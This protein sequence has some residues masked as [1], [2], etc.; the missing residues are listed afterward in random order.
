MQNIPIGISNYETIRTND[1]YYVDKTE[2][3]HELLNGNQNAV[4]L[5]T[6]PRRFGKTLAMSM[7]ANFFD[8]RKESSHL[9]KGL[10][11]E[12]DEDLCKKW[13]NQYPTIFLTFKDVNGNDYEE[14][15]ESLRC[16][17]ADLYNEYKY[18]IDDS[19]SENDQ[20]LFYALSNV[21]RGN[22]SDIVLGRSLSLLMKLVWNYYK[23]PVILLLD[24]YDVPLAKASTKGYYE[25]ML[26]LIRM[27]M[28]TAFKDNMFLKF[29]V[30]TGCLQISKESIFTG[31]NNFV[32]DNIFQSHL[33]EYFGF[34]DEEVI[35]LLED[36]G[37]RNELD[38]IKKWYDGYHFG[39]KDIYCPWDV[40]NY[41]YD[42]QKNPNTAYPR[43]YWKNT[44]DNEII[45][46]FI[47]AKSENI[48]MKLEKLMDG[49]K[50]IQTIDR[51]LTYN[52]ETGSEDNFWS[53]LYLTGYLTRCTENEF[54]EEEKRR[55]LSSNTIALKIPNAEIKEIYKDMIL[56]WF[57]ESVRNWNLNKLYEA[58][59]NKNTKVITEELNRI[60]L[61]TISY[62]DYKEDFY[63]AFLAGIFT[64]AGY[65][66]ESNR[67]HG[68]GRSDIVITNPDTYDVVIFEVKHVKQYSKLEQECD[69]A[70]EQIQS[71]K[72]SED[73]KL[74]HKKILEY[75]IC[76]YKKTCL[77]KSVDKK[78]G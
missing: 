45:H 78:V 3:I 13:M 19:V 2:M 14:A 73:F 24:E 70:I 18:I 26:N 27:M 34:T 74:S 11:I 17:I 77:V 9:F 63:H 42:K 53:I 22:P 49:E 43:S 62:Q 23:K 4:T 48:R 46:S 41:I 47:Q 52:F 71:R 40:L 64:G 30:I 29:A 65:N 31:T 60:L 10:K 28:S 66:V 33:D 72:Y 6:R 51:N 8:I 55:L 67:E 57:K 38:T 12:K 16:L 44:S 7:L 69:K 50:I 59:W 21:M 58:V 36:N 56:K 1:Y 35:Q 75:G 15:K 37:L 39:N 61:K 5:I 25:K 32:V 76:F 20:D 54:T 68:I